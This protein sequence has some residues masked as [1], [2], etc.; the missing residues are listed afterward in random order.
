ME[1]QMNTN[2]CGE[3]TQTSYG[4]VKQ[5]A[6]AGKPSDAADCAPSSAIAWN[7][8]VLRDLG[9]L[10]S[11]YARSPN[12]VFPRSQLELYRFTLSDLFDPSQA[13]RFL[14]SHLFTEFCHREELHW[15]GSFLCNPLFSLCYSQVENNLDTGYLEKIVR[16]RIIPHRVD[17]LPIRL[18]KK[19]LSGLFEIELSY[20]ISSF[21]WCEDWDLS[22][23]YF[24]FYIKWNRYDLKKMR[25]ILTA[26][27]FDFSVTL[28]LLLFLYIS[29]NN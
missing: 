9:R 16:E 22:N 19:H 29:S 20:R 10:I 1:I 7:D 14:F 27:L 18:K 15:N 13:A 2:K 21:F 26:K 5:V 28:S 17:H 23:Y 25:R 8:L 24:V 3:T 11:R 12:D 4:L 6:A